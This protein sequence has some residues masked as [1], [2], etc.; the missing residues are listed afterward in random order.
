[1]LPE[2]KQFCNTIGTTL[3]ALEEGT[4]WANK[5]ELYIQLM[6]E[7]VRKDMQVANSPLAFWD[8]CIE[9]H[10]QIYNMTAKDHFK[11]CGSNPHTFTTGEEGEILSL[12]QYTWYDWCYYQEHTAHFPYNQEVLGRALGSAKG[13]SNEMAQWVLKANGNIIPC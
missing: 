6:K 12:C 7:A 2:P 11:I 1:M 4:P 9:K 3:Q 10:A 5:A 13:K 8:Y